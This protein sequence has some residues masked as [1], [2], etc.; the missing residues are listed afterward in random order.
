M[1]INNRLIMVSSDFNPLNSIELSLIGQIPV[2]NGKKPTQFLPIAS[3]IVSN[4]KPESLPPITKKSPIQDNLLLELKQI[5]NLREE[6]IERELQ[7]LESQ[8]LHQ[9]TIDDLLKIE[10]WGYSLTSSVN[11]KLKFGI[12]FLK[13]VFPEGI[14]DQIPSLQKAVQLKDL[15]SL[16]TNFLTAIDAGTQGLALICK[17]KILIKSK[18]LLKE[19]KA[20]H[21][22]DL[23]Q[24]DSSQQISK[25]SP[26]QQAF[27]EA[28][29]KK[30]QKILDEWE[31]QIQLEE[32]QLEEDKGQFQL[33]TASYS[34]NLLTAPIEYLSIDSFV[35]KP[36]K[37]ANSFISWIAAG[38]DIVSSVFTLKKTTENIDQFNQWKESFKNWQDEHLP[39]VKISERGKFQKNNFIDASKNL[40]IKRQVLMEKKITELM[41]RFSSFQ[42]KIQ[43]FKKPQFIKEVRALR[44]ILENPR[45]TPH[46]I[47]ERFQAYGFFQPAMAVQNQ[48]LLAAFEQFKNAKL[49]QTPD[50][51]AA[52]SESQ[53]NLMDQLNQ[54]MDHPTA[55]NQQ[56]QQ[57]FRGESKENLL[58]SY[59]DHQETVEH[60]T[61][62][63]LKQMVN[64][65]HD[66]ESSFLDFKLKSFKIYLSIAVL[67]VTLNITIKVLGLLTLPMGGLG[68][69]L[70]ILS[71]G[72]FIVNLGLCA[73][74]GY[75]ASHYRPYSAQLLSISFLMK[76]AMA[77]LKTSIQ[78]YLH[79]AKDKKL[80]E[81]AK[82][83]YALHST[84][85]PTSSQKKTS[86]EYQKALA[87][88]KKAKAE[89]QQSQ[90]KFNEWSKKVNEL[91]TRVAKE[92]W[93]DFAQYASLK[94]S[95]QAADFDTLRAFQ[96]AIEACDLSLLSDET[97]QLLEVQLGVDLD[98]LQVQMNQNP[99]EIK[100]TLQK[101]FALDDAGLVKFI[102]HQKARIKK[103]L[104]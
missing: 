70:L 30:I 13:R 79:Q 90:D 39:K 85:I 86:P 11:K 18:E 60:L 25:K 32:Q 98:T 78:A 82:I 57:W 101:F 67:V 93:K 19:I 41:P 59:L 58:R 69:L 97:R 27:L 36:L 91:E 5:L 23:A 26:E 8:E 84:S 102:N 28:K 24:T 72:S 104:L 56:F 94:T 10:S 65:K 96:K 34:L 42:T 68:V 53:Q 71:N 50:S 15:A 52:V 43:D 29:Q 45:C 16:G 62:N 80:I 64:Q 87:N 100:N 38:L 61:K 55:M 31:L 46:E 7:D 4:A 76:M 20:K 21:A 2:E 63:A 92:G 74:G 73:A 77:K 6:K 83:L 99:E 103:G 9:D 1:V 75:Q 35:S 47:E 37:L 12:E 33:N 17:S 3:Y 14:F 22:Q 49:S 51:V 81:T 48:Q 88:Y 66:L 54:W 44:Q 95:D 40:L 89:F